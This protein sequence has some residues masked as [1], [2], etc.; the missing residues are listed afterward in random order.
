MTALKIVPR[1]LPLARRWIP[2]QTA[3]VVLPRDSERD[4]GEA[5]DEIAQGLDLSVGQPIVL[6]QDLAASS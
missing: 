6:A 1:S 3:P 4:I 2:S 5:V